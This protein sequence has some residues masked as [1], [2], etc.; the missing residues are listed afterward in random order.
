MSTSNQSRIVASISVVGAGRVGRAAAASLRAAGYEVHGP[1]GRGERVEP[2]DAVLLCVPDREIGEAGTVARDAAP[3]VGHT[4]GATPLAEVGVD[5][6]LHPLR[7]F[8]GTE[9]A[10]SFAGIGCAVAGTSPEALRAAEELALAVG[11]RP[12]EVRDEQRAGYHAAASI[13]SNYLVTLQAAAE[14]VAAA[15]GLPDGFRAH[16]VPLVRGTVENW[17]AL[18][19]REAL[20]GPIV[21]GDEPTVQRQRAAVEASAPG[22]L[23]LFDELTERTRALVGSEGAPA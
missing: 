1:T 7:A 2:A 20:T 3:L 23:P 19:P 22:L 6:G 15:S 8:V 5:F 14:T 9:G 16:L 11:G 17:A 18:G 4:S 12:F 10:D 21:R 13:A